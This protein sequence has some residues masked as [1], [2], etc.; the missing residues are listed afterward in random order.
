MYVCTQLLKYLIL[1]A[2]VPGEH[3]LDAGD[4]LLYTFFILWII[5]GNSPYYPIS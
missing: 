3:G 2:G 4:L 5:Q 1:T